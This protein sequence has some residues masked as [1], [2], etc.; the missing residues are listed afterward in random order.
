[1][2]ASTTLITATI[3]LSDGAT[4]TVIYGLSE[5]TQKTLITLAVVFFAYGVVKL[6]GSL[7]VG[8]RKI[9]RL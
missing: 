3:L 5:S 2:S 1:M 6:A 7:A 9:F 8:A 4:K